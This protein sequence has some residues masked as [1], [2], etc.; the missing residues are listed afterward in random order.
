MRS[1]SSFVTARPR[2]TF[3]VPALAAPF[4]CAAVLAMFAACQDQHLVAPPEPTDGWPAD[5]RSISIALRVDLVSQTVTPVSTG[6]LGRSASVQTVADRLRPSFALLGTNELGV[7]TE[8][9]TR[10]A[11]G[12]FTPRQQRVR[13]DVSLTN[14]L[15]GAAFV[16]PTFPEPP[17]GQTSLL[18]IPFAISQVVGSGDVVVSTDWDGDGTAGS[19]APHSF[20]NDIEC[21]PTRKTGPVSDC[22]RWEGFASPLDPG[23]TSAVKRVGFDVAPS[24]QSFVVEMVLAADLEDALPPAVGSGQIAFAS[25]RD[26]NTDIYVMNPD[27]SEQTRL[28]TNAGLDVS[29]AWTPDGSKIAFASDRDGTGSTEI[30]VMNADGSEPT[31]RTT[32]AAFDDSPTWSPDGS[33]IAFMSDRDGNFEIYVM[34]ADGSEQTRLTT[35][36]AQDNS[37]TWSPDGSKIAFMSR[38]DDGNFEIYVMNANGSEQTRLTTDIDV[39]DSPAWSPDGSKIAFASGRDLDTVN[40]EIYVMNADGSEQTRLTTNAASDDSPT[41]SPDGSKIAFMSNR[42][43]NSE[44]YVMNANGRVQANLTVGSGVDER[45]DWGR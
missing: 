35:N 4:V 33:K 18:L 30:Y 43:G 38:R 7:A 21:S 11:T 12:A 29:P 6:V 15:A 42:D 8:N 1:N 37:P 44:I 40:P 13:F 3:R 45:P 28:T 26:G 39:D 17:A 25:R 34:N 2:G 24:V 36:V 27:G 10:S 22:Y 20:F 31:R 14:K 9:F 5:L 19:G 41:W 23:A 16:T 32:N